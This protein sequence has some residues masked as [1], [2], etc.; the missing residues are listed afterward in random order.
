MHRQAAAHYTPELAGAAI[1]LT[2][3][4]AAPQIYTARGNLPASLLEYRYGWL[5]NEHETTFVEEHWLGDECVKRSVHTHLKD[6]G[7]SAQAEAASLA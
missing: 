5:D 1:A 2:T 3:P 6:S 7:V 4:E